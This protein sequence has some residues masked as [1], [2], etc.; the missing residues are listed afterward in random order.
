MT[1]PE[2]PFPEPRDIGPAERAS[3]HEVRPV[4]GERYRSG[5]AR[6]AQLARATAL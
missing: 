5:P 3:K 4:D 2:A 1:F 6:V